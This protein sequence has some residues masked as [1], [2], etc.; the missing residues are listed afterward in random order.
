MIELIGWVGLGI[1]SALTIYHYYM[2]SNYDQVYKYIKEKYG[3]NADDSAF[4][5]K[6][7]HM[8]DAKRYSYYTIFFAGV[9]I[10]INLYFR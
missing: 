2:H 10:F 7:G 1:S 4:P 3:G 5:S 9:L 8:R 6:Q